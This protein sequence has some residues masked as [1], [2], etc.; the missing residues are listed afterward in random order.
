MAKTVICRWCMIKKKIAKSNLPLNCPQ[1]VFPKV[2]DWTRSLKLHT[3]YCTLFLSM[4]RRKLRLASVACSVPSSAKALGEFVGLGTTLCP[5]P[6]A[7]HRST[8]PPN[9]PES[10]R[11]HADKPD[12]FSCAVELKNKLGRG[13]RTPKSRVIPYKHPLHDR[14]SR[15]RLRIHHIIPP[16]TSIFDIDQSTFAR[17]TTGSAKNG[18]C[19][20]IT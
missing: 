11:R 13:V 20:P 15:P 6:I 17:A 16:Y 10:S 19:H 8:I 1:H 18:L 7:L 9:Q 2:L 12:L 4:C 3:V 5:Q 14:P